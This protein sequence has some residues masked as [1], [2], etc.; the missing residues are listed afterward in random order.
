LDTDYCF[1]C[2]KG[3]EKAVR[4]IHTSDVPVAHRAHLDDLAFD[5]LESGLFTEDAG[6]SH[7]VI[8]VNRKQ[9]L[10]DFGFHRTSVSKE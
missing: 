9:L 7:A 3:S 10:V 2:Q 4:S 6:F 1:P 5:E 8:L